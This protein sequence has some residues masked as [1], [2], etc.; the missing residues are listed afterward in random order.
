MPVAGEDSMSERSTHVI[1]GAG[2]IG[3]PL[4]RLLQARGHAVRLVRRSGDAPDGVELRLGD[5]GD[6]TFA[7]EAARGAA[8]I[9]HCMNPAYDSKVWARELPRLMTSLTAAAGRAGARLVVLDNV[10]MLGRPGGKPLDEDSPIAPCSRKGEI[11]AKVN[12][13]LMAEH[14][15]GAVRAVVG[16]VSDF[17]GPGGG[18]TYFGDAFWP[19]ALAGGTATTL[20]NLDTP[21][22]YH[23]TLDVVA[24]LAALGEAPDDVT[25]R[26]W[27]LPCAP[28][29]STRAMIARIGRELGR[30]LRISSMP[31][32]L[33]GVLGWFVPL[34]GEL[35]EMGY[36]WDAPF[37]ADDRRFRER[38][39][40]PVT[41]LDEGVSAMI[42]WARHHYGTAMHT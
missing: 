13:Q 16:R 23:Y 40:V 20:T 33:F 36:Q 26:W 14:R 8:A 7:A 11:R 24:G 15:K 25:G 32:A 5:A 2:Q 41:P 39:T 10:Y 4:A 3:T 18:A 1:F 17:Y 34:L 30:E 22:T 31:R 21:H 19:K 42:A 38:F 35:A 37:V 9:Y 12:E 6:A 28:A 27:M 29:E